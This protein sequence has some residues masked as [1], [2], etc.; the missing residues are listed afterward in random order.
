M[1]KKELQTYFSIV[2]DSS[3]FKEYYQN[4]DDIDNI[5]PIEKHILREVL[6]TKFNLQAEQTGVYLVRSGGSTE[7]PLIF[8]VDIKENLYQRKL[9]ASELTTYRLFT[10]KTIALNIFSYKDMYRTSAILDDI[11]D[12]CYATTIALS[13]SSSYELMYHTAINFGAN[14]LMGTPS[15]LTLF[16]NYLQEN[17][18]KLSVENLLFAGESLLPSQI[19]IF[20]DSFQTKCIYSLFGSAETGIWGWT[21]FTE[22][23]AAF[24]ILDEIIVEIEDPDEEGFGNLIVTNLIRKRFPLFRYNMG[25]IAQLKIRNGKRIL[26]LKSR[27]PKSFSIDAEAYNLNDFDQLLQDIDRFQ[28]QLSLNSPIQTQIKFLLIKA[29]C[30]T[31]ETEKILKNITEGINRIIDSNPTTIDLKV[32]F[33]SEKEL[34]ADN[35][36]SKTPIII[37]FRN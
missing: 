3:L 22:N 5:A 29:N 2:K 13:S 21:N 14:I 16:A 35:T 20:E 23:S 10:P 7:R 1:F 32:T 12:R 37:D 11:L 19:K 24:E 9:L 26:T 17:D 15:K 25:D 28:I 31:I 30:T 34:F 36:T 8:P 6:D 33:V 4:E 27:A 18:L